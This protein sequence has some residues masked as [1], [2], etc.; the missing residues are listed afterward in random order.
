MRFQSTQPP[1]VE[2]L[3]G[4]QQMHAQRPAQ[5]ADCHEHVRE[6]RVLAEQLGKLVDDDEQ[7]GQ[8]RQLPA[9]QARALV[10]G[11]SGTAGHSQQ[12]LPAVHFTG[13]CIAHPGDQRRLLG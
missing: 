1:L 2:P 12:L 4:Q 5:P 10:R 11:E 7:G 13:Q 6:I 8:R 9:S 3:A